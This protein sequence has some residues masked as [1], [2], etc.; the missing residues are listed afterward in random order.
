MLVALVALVALAPPGACASQRCLQHV[1]DPLAGRV[2]ATFEG[3]DSIC[4]RLAP[5]VRTHCAECY[6]LANPLRCAAEQPS[7]RE[8]CLRID[9]DIHRCIAADDIPLQACVDH[10]LATHARA[11]AWAANAATRPPSPQSANRRNL[12]KRRGDS[13]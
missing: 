3:L 8:R 5:A 7:S 12:A 10:A 2:C 11:G 9:R 1:G 6:A 13:P 4:E